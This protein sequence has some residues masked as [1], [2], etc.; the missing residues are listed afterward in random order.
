MSFEFLGTPSR[1]VAL[2]TMSVFLFQARSKFGLSSATS[3]NRNGTSQNLRVD[4]ALRLRR[5]SGR[6]DLGPRPRRNRTHQ[7]EKEVKVRPGLYGE[8]DDVHDLRGERPRVSSRVRILGRG[9]FSRGRFQLTQTTAPA[10]QV[11]MTVMIK[12]SIT[13]STDAKLK[14]AN[15][16]RATDPEEG[17]AYFGNQSFPCEGSRTG[18]SCTRFS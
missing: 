16:V 14:L 9:C 10:E 3:A 7:S 5:G 8:D 6:Q 13:W 2:T 1:G 18:G 11:S 12:R 15:N 4:P 17:K